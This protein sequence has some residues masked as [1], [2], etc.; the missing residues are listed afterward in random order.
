MTNYEYLLTEAI[1]NHRTEDGI[2]ALRG[3][4][5]V[6]QP[7]LPGMEPN[8]TLSSEDRRKLIEIVC[9]AGHVPQ[10]SQSVIK[11]ALARCP[12]SIRIVRTFIEEGLDG[13][14]RVGPQ[15]YWHV[16]P[17]LAMRFASPEEVWQRV[18]NKT[19]LLEPK[20]DGEEC[21][22]HYGP[23]GVVLMSGTGNVIT[24]DFISIARSIGQLFGEERVILE[25]E[26][27]AVDPRDGA[28]LPRTSLRA[29]GVIHRVVVYDPLLLNGQDWTRRSSEERS[30]ELRR[31]IGSNPV[32][33]IAMTEQVAVSSL[34]QFRAYF[35]LC[36]V[37]MKLE[38][39]I[40]KDPNA[41]YQT[42]S[43]TLSRLKIKA[44]DNVDAILE[45]RNLETGSFLI[46]VWDPETQQKTP[47]AWAL[48][49]KDGKQLLDHL[50]SHRVQHPK[51]VGGKTLD[52]TFNDFIIVEVQGNRIMPSRR[53]GCGWTL[54]GALIL[55]VRKDIDIE[56]V[57]TLTEYLRITPVMGE[58]FPAVT[59]K[60][61]SGSK[62][63]DELF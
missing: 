24:G 19:W 46:S 2:R 1:A 41:T 49:N 12:D 57:T 4:L 53:F 37:D 6:Q 35:N 58:S 63:S 29:T 36:T 30:Q 44:I 28:R 16:R 20:L 26:V 56:R 42:G 9:R 47:I 21:Q 38:G 5:S 61:D 33:S 50:E 23:D 8:Q 40:A 11:G 62:G 32:P 7:S 43:R 27:I 22:I 34:K 14:E 25:G 48:T 3:L 10:T 51:T 18:E 55:N 59:A 45:G 54:Y 39:V 31:F 52:E 15:V 13:L 17:A 60:S